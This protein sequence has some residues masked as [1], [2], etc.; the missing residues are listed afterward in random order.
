MRQERRCAADHCIWHR[1]AIDDLDQS[2]CGEG[3][4]DSRRRRRRP[5]AVSMLESLEEFFLQ[6]SSRKMAQ[7]CEGGTADR[8]VFKVGGITVCF[9]SDGNHAV[10]R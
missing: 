10:E 1:E 8:L 5:E 7:M 3:W 9:Y 6:D 2:G 4:V